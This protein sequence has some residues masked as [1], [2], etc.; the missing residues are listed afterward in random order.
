MDVDEPAAPG[1][2]AAEQGTEHVNVCQSGRQKVH[3]IALPLK[4]PNTLCM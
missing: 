4:G 1:A 3:K 2:A